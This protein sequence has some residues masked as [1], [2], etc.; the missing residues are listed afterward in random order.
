MEQPGRVG[1]CAALGRVISQSNRSGV[2]ARRGP[3]RALGEREIRE[4]EVIRARSDAGALRLINHKA[5][6]LK[7]RLQAKMSGRAPR[8]EALV[9]LSAEDVQLG[10]TQYGDNHVV[11]RKNLAKAVQFH[12]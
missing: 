10:F 12:Q 9:F 7:S 1:R 4:V 8:V 5:K 2:D 3:W 6:V 11:T